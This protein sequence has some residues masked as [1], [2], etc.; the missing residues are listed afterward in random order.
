MQTP[1]AQRISSNIKRPG[2]SASNVGEILSISFPASIKAPSRVIGGISSPSPIL[3]KTPSTPKTPTRSCR[4]TP[5]LPSPSPARPFDKPSAHTLS[6]LKDLKLIAS[7]CNRASKFRD[8]IHVRLKIGVLLDNHAKY[9][10]SLKQ[11]QLC[12]GIADF[13]GERQLQALTLNCLSVTYFRLGQLKS[14]EDLTDDVAEHFHK[15]VAYS[16]EITKLY[17][18]F[19][20]DDELTNN[21]RSNLFN[22]RTN[23]GMGYIAL[24]DYT[25]AL[26]CLKEALTHAVELNDVVFE[27]IAS[28]NLVVCYYCLGMIPQSEISYQRFRQLI[29]CDSDHSDLVDEVMARMTLGS[30]NFKNAEDYFVA[31][32]ERSS[33]PELG[34]TPKTSA[35]LRSGI[36]LSRGA[37][38]AT[39]AL[40]QLS[41]SYS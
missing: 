28:G 31:S 15:S 13:L 14:T 20:L 35:M 29:R 25:S 18:Q 11:Y 22:A 24:H 16:S 12:L 4:K 5:T 10:A 1:I 6:S 19:D 27:R 9:N 7:S 41:R 32:F 2:R 23:M 40:S 33:S 21:A 17:D 38:A 8:E 34:T 3:C 26:E 36:G 30:H 37:E 39:K